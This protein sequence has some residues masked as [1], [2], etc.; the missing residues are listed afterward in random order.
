MY[1][2]YEN[3]KGKGDGWLWFILFLAILFSVLVWILPTEESFEPDNESNRQND[4]EIVVARYN[5]DMSYVNTPPFNQYPIWCYNKGTNEDFTHTEKMKIENL[6]NVGRECHT[7]LH[8]IIQN[9]D[10]LP[11]VTVF[12][13]GS[14]YNDHKKEKTMKTIHNAIQHRRSVFVYSIHENVRQHLYD[15]TLDYY[16][17]TDFKNRSLNPNANLKL[18]NIRPF[19]KWFEKWFPNTDVHYVNFGCIFAIHRKHIHN[20]PKSFY[21]E[22]IQEFTDADALEAGHY[23]ERSWNALF[24]PMDD[25]VYIN[26]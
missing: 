11:E 10:R 26:G 24:Y 9:Y 19:G 23:M 1:V 4:L 2:V 25:A 15:F 3:E 22:L 7:Y 13:S 21:E 16:E 8:H 14:A 6:P 18:A 12:L 17:P 5:E 20:R